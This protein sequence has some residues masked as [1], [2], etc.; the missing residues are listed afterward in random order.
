MKPSREKKYK[1]TVKLVNKILHDLILEKLYGRLNWTAP[2]PPPLPP[3]N[4]KNT[5]VCRPIMPVSHTLQD[6]RENIY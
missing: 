5:V 1:L 3:K 2:L 4:Y 6:D